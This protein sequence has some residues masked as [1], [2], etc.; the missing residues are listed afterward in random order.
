LI[1]LLLAL[2]MRALSVSTAY[3]VWAGIGIAGTAVVGMAILG[4]SISTQK[5]I[6]LLFLLIGILGLR[7]ASG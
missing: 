1:H 7:L 3:A 2:A 6:S 5:L 4:E